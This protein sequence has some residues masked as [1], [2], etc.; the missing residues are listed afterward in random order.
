MF[1][2]I[3]VTCIST[4]VRLLNMG[5]IFPIFKDMKSIILLWKTIIVM[6]LVYVPK[7]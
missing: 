7:K 3:I 2:Q 5:F 1:I 4:Y 6:G